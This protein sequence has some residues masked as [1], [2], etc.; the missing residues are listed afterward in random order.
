MRVLG[1]VDLA[2][3]RAVHA[4]GGVRARYA[5]VTAVAGAPIEPGSALTLAR[6]YVHTLGVGEL[7]AADLDAIA[8]RSAEPQHDGAVAATAGQDAVVTSLANLGPP[9]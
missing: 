1:V 8:A 3:G 2:G 9:L 4:R 7:Y 5:A 6:A